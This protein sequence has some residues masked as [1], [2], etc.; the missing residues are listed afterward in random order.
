MLKPDPTDL[1]AFYWIDLIDLETPPLLSPSLP[2]SFQSR[3]LGRVLVTQVLIILTPLKSA[4]LR[5]KLSKRP[6]GFR[7]APFISSLHRKTFTPMGS[8]LRA[9]DLGTARFTLSCRFLPV[10]GRIF[11]TVL[12]VQFETWLSILTQMVTMCSRKA[13]LP[14]T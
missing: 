4:L 2:I 6:S 12:P 5:Q 11:S 13:W 10:A 7:P 9:R 14:S 8:R 3:I 1:A